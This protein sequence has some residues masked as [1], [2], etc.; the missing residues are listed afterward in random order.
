[1]PAENLTHPDLI[2]TGASGRVGRLLARVW[3][4]TGASVV[5]QRRGP[6]ALTTSLAELHWSPLDGAA[7]LCNWVTDHGV[8]RAMLVLAGATPG[9]GRDLALNRQLA[10]ACLNA[11]R[12]AGITRLLVASSSA[13]YGKGRDQPWH[14][15]DKAEPTAPYGRAKLELEAA[16][17]QARARGLEVCCLRIGNVAGADALLLNAATDAPLT[18]DRFADGG[19]PLRSYI[20]PKSLARVVLALAR[21]PDRLPQVLNIA[22]PRAV[23]MADLAHAAKLDWRWQPAPKAA[24]QRLTLDCS[25]LTK[26]VP[27]AETES[28]AADIVAQWTTCRSAA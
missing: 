8:P 28:T 19:G 1:M 9:T 13:V 20:G 18:I 23:G 25:A 5:L 27:L 24:I 4:G 11:A 12:E 21:L 10:E 6:A 3:E 16:C 26:L 7:P 14:E 22:A 2:V 15:S 17:A